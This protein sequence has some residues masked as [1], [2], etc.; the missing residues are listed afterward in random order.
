MLIKKNFSERE[1]NR[2]NFQPVKLSKN[3]HS[4]SILNANEISVGKLI[5]KENVET[6]AVIFFDN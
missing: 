1:L 6:G 4:N 5:K 3:G 2:L